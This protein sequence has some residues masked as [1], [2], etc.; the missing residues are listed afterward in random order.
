MQDAGPHPIDG[1]RSDPQVAADGSRSVASGRDIWFA[2]T[3]DVQGD[4]EINFYG[5]QRLQSIAAHRQDLEGLTH[6]L[7][8][9]HYQ[10]RAWLREK[11]EGLRGGGSTTILLEADPGWG[12]SAFSVDLVNRGAVGVFSRLLNDRASRV[13][14]VAGFSAELA[15][16]CGHAP[17]DQFDPTWYTAEGLR[18]L[19][20]EAALG[21]EHSSHGR[22]LLVLDGADELI[23]RDL[24]P[25]GLCSLPDNVDLV[26]TYRTGRPPAA[27]ASN[28]EF[29]RLSLES[30]EN[31]EDLSGYLN[32]RFQSARA[33]PRLSLAGLRSEE[34]QNLV[35]VATQG[36]WIHAV[37]V[38]REFL[39]GSGRDLRTIPKGLRYYYADLLTRT[40]DSQPSRWSGE[41]LPVLAAL[42]ASRE[43][44]TARRLAVFAN[45]AE[46][47]VHSVLASEWSAV[48]AHID[49]IGLPTRF[50]PF[51]GS[52]QR[53]LDGEW[54]RSDHPHAWLAM[55]IDAASE[56][57]HSRAA[58]YL[59]HELGGLR[60]G[61]PCVD[62]EVSSWNEDI[63]YGLRHLAEHLQRAYRPLDLFDLLTLPPHE[64]QP[65]ES[66]DQQSKWAA[67][68]SRVGQPA[69]FLRDVR[70]CAHGSRDAV[71][72]E[73]ANG[74][75]IRS[76]GAW[77]GS[78]FVL[79]SLL[80]IARNTPPALLARLVET[81]NLSG[82]AAAELAR[83]VPHATQRSESLSA[84]AAAVYVTDPALAQALRVEAVSSVAL[85]DSDDDFINCVSDLIPFVP[86]EVRRAVASRENVADNYS[87]LDLLDEAWRKK[88]LE[89]D[90]ELSGKLHRDALILANKLVVFSRY[91]K[92]G[93]NWDDSITTVVAH[94]RSISDRVPE[95]YPVIRL[96]CRA[97][98]EAVAQRPASDILAEI[99]DLARRDLGIYV[100]Y[101]AGRQLLAAQPEAVVTFLLEHPEQVP[102][103]KEILPMALERRLQAHEPH[104]LEDIKLEVRGALEDFLSNG[105]LPAWRVILNDEMGNGL[106]DNGDLQYMEQAD[107]AAFAQM[108]FVSGIDTS[109]L[110]DL[111]AYVIAE[112]PNDRDILKRLIE[113]GARESPAETLGVVLAAED[114]VTRAIGLSV[115]ARSLNAEE[116]LVAYRDSKHLPDSAV[117]HRFAS[118]LITQVADERLRS[119][120]TD[121]LWCSGTRISQE[122]THPFHQEAELFARAYSAAADVMDLVGP[123]GLTRQTSFIAEQLVRGAEPIIPTAEDVSPA[124]P[125]VLSALMCLETVWRAVGLAAL[126]ATPRASVSSNRPLALANS[127][128]EKPWRAVAGAAAIAMTAVLSEEDRICVQVLRKET[129]ATIL[130]FECWDGVDSFWRNQAVEQLVPSLDLAE[131]RQLLSELPASSQEYR[132]VARLAPE[133]LTTAEARSLV[134]ALKEGHEDG[135]S[136]RTSLESQLLGSLAAKIPAQEWFAILESE[137]PHSWP[138]VISTAVNYVHIE[139]LGEL[140]RYAQAQDDAGPRALSLSRIAEAF[141]RRAPLHSAAAMVDAAR[142][143]GLQELNYGTW[144]YGGGAVTLLELQPKNATLPESALDAILHE[145]L[146]WEPKLDNL[147]RVLL[148]KSRMEMGRLVIRAVAALGGSEERVTASSRRRLTQGLT[149]L[150]PTIVEVGGLETAFALGKALHAT[151]D[152]LNLS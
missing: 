79:T 116:T 146:S 32:A 17:T 42:A 105:N 138:E 135:H 34:A 54:A 147:G 81:K 134:E 46:S 139:Q 128:P 51:H 121:C 63:L 92:M 66:K 71:I 75:P 113:R 1:D 83:E 112:I 97:A 106:R 22:L 15:V 68:Q 136:F 86:N 142:I 58:D 47:T 101:T 10:G 130:Q 103:W 90:F 67:A 4:F 69:A 111:I 50:A 148:E 29:I 84:V 133:S 78:T 13:E 143:V 98:L 14:I 96:A 31:M 124:L 21:L 61:L 151:D 140:V 80:A 72:A 33:K 150:L 88:I 20:R 127:V 64:K 74:G 91:S 39:N 145:C 35:M 45:M 118:T 28:I 38:V 126:C 41:I 57:A 108:A 114:T 8:F 119:G 2:N 44:A 107:K 73:Q 99:E 59:L 25:L 43:P 141:A 102:Y 53:I 56:S 100:A 23:N 60:N 125:D 89:V 37:L 52:L 117:V 12:K 49:R 94:L 123:M 87:L 110:L 6:Q 27:P 5:G 40:K 70:L 3:G 115:L 24:A 7:E 93:E 137:E 82:A 65:G 129:I 36:L 149:S 9:A 19:L 122:P 55:E 109:R 48:T 144:A 76:L 132:A 11:L 62:G 95:K 16:L 26:V 85:W 131:R 30:R 18:R 77:L 152:T 120:S 104:A